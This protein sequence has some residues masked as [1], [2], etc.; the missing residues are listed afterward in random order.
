M[1]TA[2][3]VIRCTSSSALRGHEAIFRCTVNSVSK[4]FLNS[5][6]CA[7]SVR[8]R[9]PLCGPSR[10]KE[11]CAQCMH[12]PRKHYENH[13]GIVSRAWGRAPVPV[14]VSGS[15]WHHRFYRKNRNLLPL[16]YGEVWA[17]Q[18]TDLELYSCT[19]VRSGPSDRAPS[20]SH[21]YRAHASG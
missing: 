20:P 19:A 4:F 1:L 14:F 18:I 8:S 13:A 10:S 11:K 15:K 9:K 6:T 16:S 2:A 3:T 21:P 5:C 12:A 17:A 7:H